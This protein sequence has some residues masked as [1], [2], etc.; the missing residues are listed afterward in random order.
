MLRGANIAP[1]N[2]D[3]SDEVRL[4]K[5][6]AAEFQQ[7]R[8][9]A[10][11]IVI[12]MD[13]PMISGGFKIALVSSEDDGALLVQRVARIRT[14]DQ[15]STTYAWHFLNSRIFIDHALS[16]ATGS[17]LPHISANDILSAPIHLPP[18]SEQEE[19]ANRLTSAFAWIDKIATEHARADH[20]LPKLDQSILAKAFRGKLVQ[21]DPNDEPASV[22]LERIRAERAAK[23]Q[24]RRRG[25]R[26]SARATAS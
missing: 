2:L 17:D 24:P 21:Q 25:R 7:Y 19:I 14:V 5:K 13:R 3:W 22:L 9:V 12:A 10:G 4:S 23:P 16:T 6:Q 15:V 11:D 1:G 18:P 8:L 26:G 20:L